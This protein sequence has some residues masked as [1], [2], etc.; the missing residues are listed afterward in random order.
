MA[1]DSVVHRFNLVN[2]LLQRYGCRMNKRDVMFEAHKSRATLDNMRNPAHRS[3]CGALADAEIKNDEGI[4]SGVPVLFRT[5]A[6][7]VWLGGQT[8]S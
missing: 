7:G 4:K 2:Y 8:K 6:I 1:G 3:Y 5:H